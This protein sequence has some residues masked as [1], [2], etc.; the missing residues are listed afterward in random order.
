[1]FL[2]AI[3]VGANTVLCRYLNAAY[4][5]YNGLSMATLMNYITGLTAALIVLFI[6][7]EP[8]AMQPIGALSFRKVMMFLGGAFGVAMVQLLI[9]IT[10]R[11]PAFLGSVLIFISQLGTGLALDYAFTGVVGT[12]KLLGGLLVVLGL[13]H[14]SWVNRA[15]AALQPESAP[16]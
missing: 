9:Y 3:F 13:A 14:Y 5:K 12:G 11:I 16:K 7:G 15:P 8:A 4:A 2:I 10:P 1:M 6:M